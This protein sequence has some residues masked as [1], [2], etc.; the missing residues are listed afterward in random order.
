MS[1]QI[2]FNRYDYFG[3]LFPGS[4]VTASLFLFFPEIVLLINSYINSVGG[5][6]Y[7][8]IAFFSLIGI[9][10]C[11]IAGLVVTSLGRWLLEDKIIGKKLGYPG[12]ILFKVNDPGQNNVTPSSHK[13]G[14]WLKVYKKP[15]SPDFIE[16][17]NKVF[18][19]YFNA[20]LLKDQ[21]DK[22]SLCF[23]TVKEH[24]PATLDRLNTFISLYGLNRNLVAAFLILS[25][26]VVAHAIKIFNALPLIWLFLFALLIYVHFKTFLKFFRTYGDEVFRTFFI[27]ASE[28]SD[29]TSTSTCS[30]S[31]KNF[32]ARVSGG[33]YS[34]RS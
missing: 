7:L 4:L 9:L 12:D 11:Y 29:P 19:G 17:F 16:S 28:R 25:G 18:S 34:S 6:N 21:K 20:T 31:R 13:Q 8:F 26:V 14:T 15:Y 33:C 24:C 30:A 1:G 22:F 2:S 27:F 32:K 3:I 23:A 10:M 5:L